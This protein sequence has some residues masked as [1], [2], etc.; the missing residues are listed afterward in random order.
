[1]TLERDDG[2]LLRQPWQISPSLSDL[3][4]TRPCVLTATSGTR[5]KLS[6]SVNIRYGSRT[7]FM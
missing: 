6:L 5:T 2:T 3:G 1:M 4:G 7:N